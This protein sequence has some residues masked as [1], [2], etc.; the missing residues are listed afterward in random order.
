MGHKA[1]V[2]ALR[3]N[4]RMFHTLEGDRR[5][6]VHALCAAVAVGSQDCSVTVWLS[7]RPKPLVVLKHFFTNVR[8]R[9]GAKHAT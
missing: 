1:P 7:T 2:V 3:Y 8:A 9:A 6:G 4:N 5:P